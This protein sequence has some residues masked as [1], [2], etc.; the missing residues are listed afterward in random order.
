[1]AHQGLP[2]MRAGRFAARLE[3]KLLQYNYLLA[4]LKGPQG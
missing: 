2:Q 4:S 1:M 3:P